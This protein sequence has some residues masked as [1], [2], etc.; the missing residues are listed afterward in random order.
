MFATNTLTIKGTGDIPDSNRSN[1][2]FQEYIYILQHIQ[3]DENITSIGSYSFYK[4]LTLETVIIEGNL[5]EIRIDA[6]Y[7]CSS[8]SSL[9][10]KG[11]LSPGYW[12][13][14]FEK[15]DK[16]TSIDVN[17][18]YKSDRFCGIPT[19][20]IIPENISEISGECGNG[21][22]F[23][24]NFPTYTL[25]ITGTGDMANYDHLYNNQP[26]ANYRYIVRYLNIEEGITSI[27]KNAFKLF[28]SLISVNLSNSVTSIQSDAFRGCIELVSINI[29]SIKY[30]GSSVFQNCSSLTLFEV[31]SGIDAI[32]DLL[33]S[34][35]SS[36]SSIYI[37]NTIISINTSAF[38]NCLSLSTINIPESVVSIGS[39]AFYKCQSL[40]KIIIPESVTS[41]GSYAFQY[42]TSLQSVI[43]NGNVTFINKDAFCNC[44][45]LTDFLYKGK[46]QTTLKSGTL[47]DFSQL[48]V[49][50]VMYYYNYESY[51]GKPIRRIIPEGVEEITGECGTNLVYKYNFNSSTLIIKGNGYMT[52]YTS[53]YSPFQDIKYILKHINIEENVSSIGSFT[54]FNCSYLESVTIDSNLTGI[55]DSSFL[56]C[57]SLSSIFYKGL[58]QPTIEATSFKG[59]DNL[60]RVDVP[61]YYEGDKFGELN[62]RKPICTSNAPLGCFSCDYDDP[63][64]CVMCNVSEF[65]NETVDSNG[66]CQCI[67]NYELDE[68]NHCVPKI[69]SCN[70]D[71]SDLGCSHCYLYDQSICVECD[72]N[73][74]FKTDPTTSNK[75]ECINPDYNISQGECVELPFE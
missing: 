73:R 53:E 75:C 65:F 9:L 11:R 26:Y 42:C 6:F 2:I 58:K 32:P 8:L 18:Y 17:Y 37:P 55:F 13:S 43:I 47:A 29:S 46:I 69:G 49:V 38:S 72:A 74:G 51:C 57:S 5:T 34:H 39:T 40:S 28:I 63:S 62:I 45:S 27:G 22:T 54:F 35:C 14:A 23:K 20:L 44:N 59:C 16:L 21:I 3:I 61:Y 52:N 33:L 7:L 71:A 50:D 36:I 1:S 10:Y 56:N 24:Y 70:K 48:K 66:Q 60:A 31:P 12:S 64:Q 19:N 30:L 41:I 25:A 4:F 15:C 67:N 68:N